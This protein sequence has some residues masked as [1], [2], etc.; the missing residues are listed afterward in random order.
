MRNKLEIKELESRLG[1]RLPDLQR[2]CEQ[3]QI[4]RLELFGSVLRPDFDARSDIDIM[5]TFA[6]TVKLNLFRFA[7]IQEDLRELLRRPVDLVMRSA[8]EQST[9]PYRRDEIL[10]TAETLYAAKAS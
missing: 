5:A 9:N 1:V 3:H 2:F 10:Q 4:V 6:P 7:D 8:I